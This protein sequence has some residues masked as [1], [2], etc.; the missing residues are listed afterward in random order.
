MVFLR[1][2][3]ASHPPLLILDLP[4]SRGCNPLPVL[5]FIMQSL[6][7][8]HSHAL[9]HLLALTEN[10]T[11]LEMSGRTSVTSFVIRP[12]SASCLYAGNGTQDALLS[13]GSR[14]VD[15][16]ERGNTL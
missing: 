11:V 14:A 9:G 16:R 15:E 5:S 1:D 12:L 7:V 4:L 13:P 6:P 2:A 3:D 10:L 8:R